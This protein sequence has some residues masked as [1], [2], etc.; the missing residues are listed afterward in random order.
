V[1]DN[2]MADSKSF[3]RTDASFP[4]KAFFGGRLARD[5]PLIKD[6]SENKR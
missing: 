1:A 5:L 3:Y 4:V 6:G 2:L